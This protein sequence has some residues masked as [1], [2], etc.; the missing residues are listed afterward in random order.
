MGM[1]AVA[2]G[3]ASFASKFLRQKV[4]ILLVNGAE[5]WRAASACFT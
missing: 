4:F 3:P 1:E 5:G 2:V